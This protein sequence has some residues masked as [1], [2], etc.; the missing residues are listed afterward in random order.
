MI[1]RL[2]FAVLFVVPASLFAADEP[3]KA[4]AEV[5]GMQVLFNGKDLSGWDGDP[6]LWS[7]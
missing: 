3:V 2:V 1:R 5:A 6:R 4:P 7:V